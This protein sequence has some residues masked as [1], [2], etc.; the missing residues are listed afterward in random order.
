MAARPA[1]RPRRGSASSDEGTRVPEKVPVPNQYSG[2]IIWVNRDDKNAD[3]TELERAMDVFDTRVHPLRISTEPGAPPA[4]LCFKRPFTAESMIN[5]GFAYAAETV[6]E[7]L[8]AHFLRYA[9]DGKSYERWIFHGM[10]E[11][12]DS[13]WRPSAYKAWLTGLKEVAEKYPSSELLVGMVSCNI[14]GDPTSSVHVGVRLCEEMRIDE[15]GQAI[16]TWDGVAVWESAIPVLRERCNP[17]NWSSRFFRH[18]LLVIY[19]RVAE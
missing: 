18:A 17:R 11:G 19:V 16:D 12:T 10:E 7:E 4:V 8:N 6:N 3:P 9:N 15:K 5:T 13:F 2:E 1:K 14:H